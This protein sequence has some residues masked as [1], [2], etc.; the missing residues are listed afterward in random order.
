MGPK[1]LA[2]CEF[3]EQTGKRA[4]DRLD[5]GHA[6]AACAATPEPRLRSMQPGSS[7]GRRAE[8]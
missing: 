2:A 6:G 1:V 7:S 8:T 4:D 3:V 5:D